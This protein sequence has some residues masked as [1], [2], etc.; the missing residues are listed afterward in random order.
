MKQVFSLISVKI[1][2]DFNPELFF[3]FCRKQTV[4]EV[5]QMA[6]LRFRKFIGVEKAATRI[7]TKLVGKQHDVLVFVGSFR[8]NP[9]SPIKGYQR[10]P[11]RLLL[12]KL[13]LFAD[14]MLIDEF[15]TTKLCSICHEPTFISRNKHRYLVCLNQ[16]CGMC[17][18]RDV[19]AGNNMVYKGVSELTGDALHPNY[20][21]NTNLAN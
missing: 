16:Q 9:N 21:R 17:W 3:F 18:N 19:N 4:Y 13:R 14:V 20:N 1:S 2:N 8:L 10:T 7:A 11:F 12:S 5:K 6:R 15:R